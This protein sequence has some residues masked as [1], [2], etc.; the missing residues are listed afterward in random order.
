M[1]RQKKDFSKVYKFKIA[2]EMKMVI[3]ISGSSEE[4]TDRFKEGVGMLWIRRHY[5]F[6]MLQ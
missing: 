4:G 6:D 1:E 2:D 3:L 5:T